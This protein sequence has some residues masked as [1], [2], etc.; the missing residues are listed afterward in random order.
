MVSDI[1]GFSL[2]VAHD[3]TKLQA[4]EANITP[5]IKALNPFFD[6]ASLAI[7]RG[8]EE[9]DPLETD[10]RFGFVA[11]AIF[12]ILPAP[13]VTLEKEQNVPIASCRYR[14]IEELDTETP[15]TLEFVN[16]LIPNPGAPPT[17]VNYTIGA[18][19]TPPA[20]VVD[21]EVRPPIERRTFTRSL[22]RAATPA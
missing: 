19:S 10:L 11:A 16:D 12:P 1:Q 2:G 9:V 13:G 3:P 6:S 22:A 7:G 5:N 4:L 18:L 15:I 17:N 20:S 14:V 21:G 8:A